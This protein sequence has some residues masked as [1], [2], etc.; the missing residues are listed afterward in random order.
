MLFS[1]SVSLIMLNDRVHKY[2]FC[3]VAVAVAVVIGLSK[4]AARFNSFVYCLFFYFQFRMTYSLGLFVKC[5]MFLLI[6]PHSQ[7][8]LPCLIFLFLFR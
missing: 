3:R 2:S 6:I 5:R 1:P 8:L 4:D 7:L